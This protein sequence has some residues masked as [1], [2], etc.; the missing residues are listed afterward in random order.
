VY[1]F[2]RVIYRE[3]AP[4]VI[5]ERPSFQRETNRERVLHACEA[6][7]ERLAADRRHFAKPACSLFKEIRV[8]FPISAQLLVY[9][10]IERNVDLALQFL[11]RFPELEL[12]ANGAPRQCQAMTRKG[13]PCRRSPLPRSEYCP[14]H[15]HL[16]E[17]FEELD[18]GLEE[19]EKSL[20]ELETIELAA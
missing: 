5:D 9:T 19:F 15:Q 6:A 13:K 16:T 14:S 20:R 4:H 17:D 7:M 18:E 2:S 1:Q 10:A 8:Y 3:L 12:S 11:D